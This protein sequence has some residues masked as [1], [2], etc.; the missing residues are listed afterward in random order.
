MCHV[1]QKV[2]ASLALWS[3][4]TRSRGRSRWRVAH[5]GGACPRLLG[6]V[7]WREISKLQP[8]WFGAVLRE[9]LSR[10]MHSLT[11]GS[12]VCDCGSS[13]SSS[14]S[15]SRAKRSAH[16]LRH[17]A[18]AIHPPTPT[19]PPIGSSPGSTRRREVL[20]D[21]SRMA[22]SGRQP[23]CAAAYLSDLVQVGD[24]FAIVDRT[25]ESPVRLWREGIA[26]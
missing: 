8:L 12:A 7:E 24:P 16:R 22:E 21:L 1:C 26:A 2:S 17:P 6:G 18:F 3:S 5:D 11:V 23:A 10:R 4:S 14:A 20:H 9:R 15:A 19:L 13:S 25:G